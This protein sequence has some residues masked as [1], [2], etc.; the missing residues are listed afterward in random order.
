MA[1]AVLNRVENAEISPKACK[2]QRYSTP[3]FH[4][5][6]GFLQKNEILLQDFY[7]KHLAPPGHS[8][9]LSVQF[10]SQTS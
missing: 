6:G 5:A 10:N 4:R 9:I 7:K 2:L 8:G 3:I 1:A